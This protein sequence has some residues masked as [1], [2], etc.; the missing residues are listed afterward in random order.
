MTARALI[1][2]AHARL[3]HTSPIQRIGQG[4]AAAKALAALAGKV[5]LV[6]AGKFPIIPKGYSGLVTG[7]GASQCVTPRGVR[8]FGGLQGGGGPPPPSEGGG[9]DPTPPLR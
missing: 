8:Q 1:I 9:G 5:R 2:A 7:A 3:I 4:C 6:V